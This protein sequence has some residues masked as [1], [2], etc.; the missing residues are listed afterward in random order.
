MAAGR[1]SRAEPPKDPSLVSCAVDDRPA[2]QLGGNIRSKSDGQRVGRYCLLHAAH[3]MLYGR[4]TRPDVLKDRPSCSHGDPERPS[5]PCPEPVIAN[6]RCIR[7]V[8]TNG[9]MPVRKALELWESAPPTPALSTLTE[10]TLRVLAELEAIHRRGTANPKLPRTDDFI[11]DLF[12]SAVIGGVVPYT[13]R[14]FVAH[15]MSPYILGPT[16][17]IPAEQVRLHVD[18]LKASGLVEPHQAFRLPRRTLVV[19][20]E[21]QVTRFDAWRWRL[22]RARQRWWQIR[23]YWPGHVVV[24]LPRNLPRSGEIVVE[25]VFSGRGVVDVRHQGE[26]VILTHRGHVEL[27]AWQERLRE[28]KDRSALRYLE[29]ASPSPRYSSD[30]PPSC[31]SPRT[32]AVPGRPSRICGLC[33]PRDGPLLLACPPGLAAADSRGRRNTDP[34]SSR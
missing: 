21:V 20:Q 34:V 31:R 19:F 13:D 2:F 26:V 5:R 22:Q 6:G 11:V 8:S 27:R 25:P 23:R 15:E 32:H 29:G 9:L 10:D 28:E 12:F 18:S 14:V 3:V 1:A 4:P 16:L 30:W 7:Q 17:H 24:G 33:S